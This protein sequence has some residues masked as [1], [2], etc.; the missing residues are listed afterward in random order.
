MSM[1]MDDGTLV[2]KTPYVLSKA[3]SILQEIEEK[4]FGHF[5]I[6]GPPGCGKMTLL[7]QVDHMLQSKA[8]VD[9]SEA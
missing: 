9:K 7:R 4:P 2:A 1:V 8:T 3:N 6:R 5:V